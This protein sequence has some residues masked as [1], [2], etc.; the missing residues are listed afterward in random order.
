MSKSETP[1]KKSVDGQNPQNEPTTAGERSQ[2]IANP[3]IRIMIESFPPS[4]TPEKQR[5][6]K[7]R[8]KNRREWGQF[9]IS[10]GTLLVVGAYTCVS[11][12]QWKTMDRTFKEVQKQTEIQRNTGI[13]TE[14]A[15]IGLDTPITLD[16]IEIKSTQTR[17]KGHYSLKNFGHG[18]AF[19]VIQS[20]SFVR[21]G[22]NM[23]VQARE[24]N[25][26]CDSSI[27][28]AT[29]AVPVGGEMKQPPPF[30]RI[31]FPDKADS[32]PIEFQGPSDT[33]LHLRFIGCVAYI[34][35]FKTVHWTKFCMERR[36]GD[37][38]L[39]PKLDFCAMYNDTDELPENKH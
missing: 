33:V 1:N 4:P 7:K 26:Y 13:N 11:W 8:W 19:K 20:G 15:W 17:I 9:I 2:D 18:P 39:I 30:G 36:P 27:K 31:L 6:S 28:F 24:A 3:P 16:A 14:R 23:E 35:Q 12:Q 10:L 37:T 29:G 32:Y 22:E 5:N 38:T 25:F 34:D 21:T